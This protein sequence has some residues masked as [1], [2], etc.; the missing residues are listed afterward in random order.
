LLKSDFDNNDID[1]LWTSLGDEYFLRHSPN[2]TA[3]HTRLLLSTPSTPLIDIY[4][5]DERGSTEIFVYTEARDELFH[6]ITAA[7]EKLNL[8]VV[9]AGIITTQDQRVLDTFY[10]LEESG[11]II[12]NDL[13]IDEIRNALTS[14][15]TNEDGKEW[16]I[17]RRVPRTYQHFQIETQI[18]FRSDET[19]QRTIMELVTSDRPGLLSKVGKA[20]N[21]CNIRLHNAKIAT[22]G[23]RAEDVYYIT[24]RD[25]KPLTDE[26]QFDCLRKTLASYLDQ[27]KTGI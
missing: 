2:Q 12:R 25:N 4:P 9:D 14:A 15:L 3:R 21:E 6:L 7:L 17:S 13:R 26:A 23:A 22:L 10:V 8:N 5:H 19:D 20:F 16:H 18:N 27:E 1:T 11:E 24:D